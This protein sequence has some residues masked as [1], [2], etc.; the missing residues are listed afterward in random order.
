M[1]LK[2]RTGPLA[3]TE[4]GLARLRQFNVAKSATVDFDG[5]VSKDGHGH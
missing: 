2:I 4:V 3:P 1:P 5:R